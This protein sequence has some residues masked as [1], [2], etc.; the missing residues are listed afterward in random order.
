MI[1]TIKNLIVIALQ[2][3]QL[4]NRLDERFFIASLDG[5]TDYKLKDFCHPERMYRSF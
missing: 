2:E 1:V 3:V 5:I 4:R